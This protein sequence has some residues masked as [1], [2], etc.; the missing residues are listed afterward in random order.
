MPSDLPGAPSEIRAAAGLKVAALARP[1][2]A[3]EGRGANSR[4]PSPEGEDRRLVPT[5]HARRQTEERGRLTADGAVQ[6]AG[7]R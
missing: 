4:A 7:P 2:A 5:G 6:L 1:R 3:L